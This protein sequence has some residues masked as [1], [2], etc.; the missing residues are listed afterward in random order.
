[1]T[2]VRLIRSNL[3][4][5]LAADTYID[6]Y[7]LDDLFAT[8]NYKPLDLHLCVCMSKCFREIHDQALENDYTEADSGSTIL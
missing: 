5:S 3:S 4:S 7:I 8:C 2:D 6:I 1:M